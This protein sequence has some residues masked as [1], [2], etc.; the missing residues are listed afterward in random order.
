MIYGLAGVFLCQS[1]PHHSRSVEVSILHVLLHFGE[2]TR[3]QVRVWEGG[4]HPGQAQTGHEDVY[5]AG[6][7]Q[8]P[9]KRRSFEQPGAEKAAFQ[10]RN[11]ILPSHYFSPSCLTCVQERVWVRWRCSGRWR[12]AEQGGNL[13]PLHSVRPTQTGFQSGGSWKPGRRGCWTEELERRNNNNNVEK[14]NNDRWEICRKEPFIRPAPFNS[15]SSILS[16]ID[17]NSLLKFGPKNIFSFLLAIFG[18][19]GMTRCPP[20]ALPSTLSSGQSELTLYV[21]EKVGADEREDHNRDGQSAVR[22]HLPDFAIKI[23]A[24]ERE[25]VKERERERNT[26]QYCASVVAKN[27]LIFDIKLCFSLHILLLLKIVNMSEK[28]RIT[29]VTSQNATFFWF[30]YRSREKKFPFL[31]I[32][33][34]TALGPWSVPTLKSTPC[35]P[36][37]RAHPT[38]QQEF[39]CLAAGRKLSSS[40]LQ[41]DWSRKK[42][43]RVRARKRNKE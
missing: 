17:Q 29:G 40:V 43:V 28:T 27:S 33:C 22:H 1:V 10:N 30:F 20:G 34:L 38:L 13:V 5:E 36:L 25:R 7:H 4:V 15:V 37:A 24:A 19:K 35:G 6:Q 41:R 32:L 42:L 14:W 9:V 16:R 8:V 23:R 18:M 11:H 3:V 2:L 21:K 26:T 31:V 39:S 12:W